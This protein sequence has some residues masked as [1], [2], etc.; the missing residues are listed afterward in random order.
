MHGVQKIITMDNPMVKGLLRCLHNGAEPDSVPGAINLDLWRRFRF[1][2]ILVP[3]IDGWQGSE[4]FP[5]SPS[6]L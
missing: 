4:N 5:G 6:M 3:G 2:K 1:F